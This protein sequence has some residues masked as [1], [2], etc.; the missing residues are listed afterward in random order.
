MKN[1]SYANRYAQPNDKQRK[2][3]GLFRGKEEL[4]LGGVI[5]AGETGCIVQRNGRKKDREFLGGMVMYVFSYRIENVSNECILCEISL[6][7]IGNALFS[8]IAVESRRHM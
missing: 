4:F 3:Q 2:L 5:S 6:L 1:V 7:E 8:K